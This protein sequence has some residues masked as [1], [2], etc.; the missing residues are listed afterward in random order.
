MDRSGRPVPP[1]YFIDHRSANSDRTEATKGGALG[2]VITVGRAKIPKD[3]RTLKIIPVEVI[4]QLGG[5]S[6]GKAPGP[7]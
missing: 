7:R 2:D 4:R 3:A 1:A 6:P 5:A